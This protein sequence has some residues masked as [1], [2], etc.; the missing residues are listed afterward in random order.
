MID[1]IRGDRQT[2]HTGNNID[3]QSTQGAGASSESLNLDDTMMPEDTISSAAEAAAFAR[4]ESFLSAPPTPAL[5]ATPCISL[6]TN[7]QKLSSENIRIGNLRFR[8]L[9]MN[10]MIPNH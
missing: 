1:K 10:R 8:S 3:V 7:G 6:T 5:P 4:T 2:T 9:N